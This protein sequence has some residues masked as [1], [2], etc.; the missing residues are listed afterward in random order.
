LTAA[1]SARATYGELARLFIRL[2]LTAFGGPPA[3]L[4]MAEDEVVR[5][6]GWL[7]REQFLDLIAATNLIPGPNSTETMIHVGYTQRGV[8]GAVLAGACF[9]IPAALISLA[10]A[11]LYTATGALPAVGTL[12]WGLRPAIAAIIA[13]AAWR[14]TPAALKNRDLAALFGASLALLVGGWLPEAAVIVG[15]GLLY[16]LYRAGRGAAAAL[17]IPLAQIAVEI[18]ERASAS[19]LDL[20]WYFLRI[21]MVLFGSGY[22]LF[23]YIQGDVVGAFGWLTQRQLLDAI[24]IGQFTP[25]P[26]LTTSTVVG[27]LVA[28]LSGALAATVGI[29]LPS[30]VL[31]LITAPY[32]PRMR[33][34]RFL[35]AFLDG[36]N[37]AVAAAIAATLIDLGQTALMPLANAPDAVAG[38]SALSVALIALSL[39]ALMRFRINATWTLIACGAVG[40]AYGSLLG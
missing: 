9:I 24:A 19:A 10:L 39:I 8:V 7:T 30:F 5:R 14:L 32:I 21:G 35:S 20:F 17:L 28:D 22:V 33:R 27:Y 25:G 18:G 34:S 26:V 1:L 40:L 15:A 36:A 4:A 6:R 38:V 29:F 31:V 2:S 3:H 11:A 23:A 16:A 12:F 13:V 37:A